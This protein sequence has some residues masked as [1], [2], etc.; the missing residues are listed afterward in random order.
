MHSSR[1]K[2]TRE[3]K[4]AALGRLTA[5]ASMV[6]VARSCEIHPNVLWRWK[7]DFVRAPESAFPGPGRS[8][9]ESR[10]AEL[11]RQIDEQAQEIDNLKQRIQRMEKIAV[12]SGR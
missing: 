10:V 3:F 8:P 4:I 11:R 1:R 6:E 7:R 2:Y 12:A 5:G 9:Q